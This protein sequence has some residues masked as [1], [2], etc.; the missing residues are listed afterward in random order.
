MTKLDSGKP[1]EKSSLGGNTRRISLIALF[2]T[3]VFI[4]KALLPSPLDKMAV[5]MQ[6]LFLALGSLLSKPLGATKVAV[7]GAA[8]TILL[9]PSLAPITIAFA[10]IYGFLT[11]GFIFIFHVKAPEDEVRAKRLVAAMT[12]STAITGVASYLV[13]VHILALLPRNPILEVVILVVGVIS[14]LLGGYL[15][16][17]I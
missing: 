9:R 2:G 5:V 14:G 10:L 12:L 1:F 17:L 15:A 8:L 11:D 6:P 13:T 7:V 4:S 16:V 3:L